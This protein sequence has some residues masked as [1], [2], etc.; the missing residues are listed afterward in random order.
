MFIGPTDVK[1][2]HKSYVNCPCN[3]FKEKRIVLLPKDNQIYVSARM[4]HNYIAGAC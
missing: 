1:P 3:K 2:C 4:K